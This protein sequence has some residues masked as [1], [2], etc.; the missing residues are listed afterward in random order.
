LGFFSV[1]RGD[2]A[3]QIES[4]IAQLFS[5]LMGRMIRRLVAASFLALFVLA[6]LYHLTI[7]GTLALETLY[8]AVDTRLIV[9]GIYA[10]SAV[11]IF[12]C[13]FATR[14][15][16]PPAKAAASKARAHSSRRVP[17]DVRVAELLESLL[18]GYATA[19]R[20]SR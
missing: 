4:F 15:K 5:R 14:T 10:A 2:S 3:M 16:A 11:V 19:R 6:A 13:L 17:Q 1:Q 9:A 12:I 7:A 8:G 18:L 20:K